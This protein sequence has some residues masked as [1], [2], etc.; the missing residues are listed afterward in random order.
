MYY[1]EHH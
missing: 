1:K